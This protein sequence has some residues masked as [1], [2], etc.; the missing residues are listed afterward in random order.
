MGLHLEGMVDGVDAVFDEMV[1]VRRHLHRHPE[2]GFEEFDTTALVRSRLEGLG[3][4]ERPVVTPTG[5]AYTLIGGLPGRTVVLRADIDA[6]PIAE[7]GSLPFAS[8]EEGKMHA[9]GHD[10][11]TAVLL[12][13]AQ[14]LQGRAEELSGSFTFIFQP[15]E[16]LLGGA[17]QMVEGGVLDGLEGGVTLGHHVTSVLPAGLVGMRPGIAM[18]EVHTF[19][20]VVR[21]PGGHGAISAQQGDVV[22]AICDAVGRLGAVVEGLEYEHV[23][24]VCSAGMVRAGTAPNVLPDQASLRGTLRT[25]TS[26]HR[27]EALGRLRSLCDRVGSDH[28]VTVQLEVPGSAP[29]VTNDPFTTD[30]VARVARAQ[31]GTEKVMAMPPVTPSDDMSVFLQRIPGCYFFVG[32]AL[33]DGTSGMHHSP[34]F[35]IDEEAMR[36][37]ARVMVGAAVTLADMTVETA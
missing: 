17:R 34:T 14:V 8:V 6:L 25:F 9:C 29:A 15:A 4:T 18:A 33:P 20:I 3:L 27:A 10:A 36:L 35:A 5:T 37:A 28:G 1:D 12:G 30:T 11:H 22:R 24:C 26:E 7:E 31:L 16:E 23:A 21:G 19:A 13:V 32:G 2:L